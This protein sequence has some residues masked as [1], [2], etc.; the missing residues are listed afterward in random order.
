MKNLARKLC[1]LLLMTSALTVAGHIYEHCSV[2][3]AGTLISCSL[4]NDIQGTSVDAA[5][6]V[7]AGLVLLFV[8]PFRALAGISFEKIHSEISRAPPGAFLS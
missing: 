7:D 4:C 6:Q 5:P 8:E 3:T 1:L 2:A